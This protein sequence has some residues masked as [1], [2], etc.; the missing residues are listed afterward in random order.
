MGIL[1]LPRWNIFL[2]EMITIIINVPLPFLCLSVGG[3]RSQLVECTAA[4]SGC[5]L[6]YC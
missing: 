4:S 1:E 2:K 6:L 3:T 5:L